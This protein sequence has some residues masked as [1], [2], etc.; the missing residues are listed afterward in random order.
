MSH[1]RLVLATALALTLAYLLG[2]WSRQ[3]ARIV[4]TEIERTSEARGYAATYV[5]TAA[6]RTETRTRTRTVW[7][8]TERG[9]EVEQETSTDTGAA[10]VTEAQAAEVR[11]EYRDRVVERPRQDWALTALAGH[12]GGMVYGGM[13]S[14]RILGP[15]ELGAWAT[16]GRAWAAGAA[17]TL[18]W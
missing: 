9:P 5:Q 3:P 16:H 13:V 17:L 15:V 4:S 18:R 11:V 14:R 2:R 1:A 10:S 8:Q 6:V 7:R 12:D